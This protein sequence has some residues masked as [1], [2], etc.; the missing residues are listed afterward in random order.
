MFAALVPPEE[1]AEGL[2]D[3]LAPRRDAA[4][5]RWTSPEQVHLTL[6]FYADVPEHDVE[7]LAETIADTSARRRALRLR[8]AGGGAFPDPDR[9][10]VL[11]AG[12]EAEEDD[13]DELS[14][15]AGACRRAGPRVGTEVDGQRFR[16]H[17]TVARCGRPTSLT[18]WVRLLDSYRGPPWAAGEVS[19]VASY[20]GEG[21]RR[22]PRYQ[23]VAV[24]PL[25]PSPGAEG[26]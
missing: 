6:A 4:P 24:A 15:L 3:F 12:V 2:A 23:V 11:V 16:P 18:S 13:R 20:L 8:V 14:R 7:A 21:P 10:R 1:V 26:K 19:L 22:R 9:G 25:A 5:F 17:L